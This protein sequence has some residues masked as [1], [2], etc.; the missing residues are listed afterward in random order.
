MLWM[1]L[2]LVASWSKWVWNWLEIYEQLVWTPSLTSTSPG[3]VAGSALI[4]KARWPGRKSSPTVESSG[5]CMADGGELIIHSFNASKSIRALLTATSNVSAVGCWKMHLPQ[6]I[7]APQRTLCFCASVVV[8]LEA[9]PLHVADCSLHISRSSLPQ[10]DFGSSR[11][12]RHRNLELLVAQL[13]TQ[14][15]LQREWRTLLLQLI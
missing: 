13:Q 7:F 10:K 12:A 6:K 2:A 8:L 1:A 4:R 3:L 9:N 15:P 14:R 11:K 5:S